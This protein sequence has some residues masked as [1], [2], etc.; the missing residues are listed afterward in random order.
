MAE[1]RGV[2]IKRIY[3]PYD[4]VDGHRVL[5]DRLWPRGVSKVAA[6]LDDWSKDLAP[7]SALRKW[8]GHRPE[9]FAEFRMRYLGELRQSVAAKNAGHSLLAHGR[10]TLLYAAASDTCNHALVLQEFISELQDE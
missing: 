4:K 1:P 6:R 10:V 7:S 3:E 2:C 9:K 5:V 8:F